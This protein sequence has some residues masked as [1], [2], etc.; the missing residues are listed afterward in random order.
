VLARRLE[1]RQDRAVLVSV[2]RRAVEEVLVREFGRLRV[3]VAHATPTGGKLPTRTTVSCASTTGAR[4]AVCV[5][6]VACASVV[7][8]WPSLTRTLI[9]WIP[10]VVNACVTALPRSRTGSAVVEGAVRVEVEGEGPALTRAV[11]LG[12]GADPLLRPVTP[13]PPS[14]TTEGA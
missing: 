1:R 7:A 6:N 3:V 11:V 4:L 10:S 2:D 9:G 14:S 8:P 13:S 5:S 12:V